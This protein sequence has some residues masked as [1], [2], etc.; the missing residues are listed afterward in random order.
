VREWWALAPTPVLPEATH[1]GVLSA[2]LRRPRPRS[3]M[4]ALLRLQ[5]AGMRKY[6]SLRDDVGNACN[7][8]EVPTRPFPLT[9]SLV[10]PYLV[11]RFG[12]ISSC[13]ICS[14]PWRHASADVT[15]LDHA[16]RGSR[17]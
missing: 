8:A 1:E 3:T 7:E 2:Q 16:A 17:T 14:L 4:P 6:R 11:A 12:L 5:P 10:S 15:S 9:L 13:P